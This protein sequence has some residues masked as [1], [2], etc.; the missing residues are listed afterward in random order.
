MFSAIQKQFGTAGLVVAI[1]ALAAAL[2]G[3]AYAATG[4]AN[5][6]KAKRGSSHKAKRRGLTKHQVIV[7]IKKRAARGPAGPQGPPGAQ[8]SP[9]PQGLK[10]DKGDT[11]STGPAG[12]LPESLPAG[13]TLKGNWGVGGGFN[14][15]ETWSAATVSFPFPLSSAPTLV[16]VF[17]NSPGGGITGASSSEGFLGQA[18]T[19]AL[20]P[21]D[22]SDPKAT[23]G[24]LCMYT[25]QET[26]QGLASE[27]PFS[28]GQLGSVDIP[29]KF[30]ANV[31]FVFREQGTAV[32][33]WAVKA[34]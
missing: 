20:C 3:G 31:M 4:G 10:G 29:T 25:S 6:S 21:G 24:N 2:G 15:T 7:L 34:G 19:E 30:G 17:E 9:G 13:K 27:P 14:E 5:S 12:P 26:L 16:Y 18:Q 23:A 1:V 33:S 32:G 28:T 11:G 8:G 22:A